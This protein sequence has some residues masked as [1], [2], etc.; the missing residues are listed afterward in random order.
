MLFIIMAVM[1]GDGHMENIRTWL[2][3]RWNY[4]IQSSMKATNHVADDIY[5]EKNDNLYVISQDSMHQCME[6]GY[7]AASTTQCSSDHVLVCR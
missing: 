2:T 3:Y 4:E 7:L 1:F 6:I 5:C